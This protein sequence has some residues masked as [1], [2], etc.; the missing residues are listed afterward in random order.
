VEAGVEPRSAL[1]EELRFLTRRYPRAG[2][3]AHPRLGELARYWLGRHALFRELDRIIRSGT[4]EALA[5]ASEPAEF[6]PWLARHLQTCLWQLQGHHQIEDLHYFP[7]FCRVEP[8]LA[9]G[10]ELLENDHRAL[11]QAL[12]G[13]VEIANRVLAHEGADLA[14]FCAELARFRDAQANLGRTL[15]RHLDDEEDLV[16][17]LLLERGEGALTG[18]A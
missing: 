12:A 1:S 6:K 7:V 2:W 18:G 16:V 10:F 13:I 11:H 3:V 5:A 14:H 8:R 9:A 15:L 4:E 17:P